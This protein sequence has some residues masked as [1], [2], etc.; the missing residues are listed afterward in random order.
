MKKVS[1]NTNDFITFYLVFE[2]F[3]KPTSEREKQKKLQY[4]RVEEEGD[5][6]S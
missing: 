3:R 6:T 5:A 2:L 4:K 1:N